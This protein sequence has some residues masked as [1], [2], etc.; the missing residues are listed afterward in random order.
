MIS[1]TL[2]LL[3]RSLR[4]DTRLL[5]SHAAQFLFVGIIYFFLIE[6][7]AQSLFPGAPGLWFFDG[8]SWL[9]F[10]FILAVAVSFCA[11]AITEE[12]EEMTLAA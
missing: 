7:Q 9:N 2:A 4:E 10:W 5:R 11:T 12:K 6:A 1:S 3:N 8:I